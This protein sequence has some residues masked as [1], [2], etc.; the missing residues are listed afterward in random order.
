MRIS[1]RLEAIDYLHSLGVNAV[2]Y[3]PEPIDIRRDEPSRKRTDSSKCKVIR[4][5]GVSA[6]APAMLASG[7]FCHG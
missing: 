3:L 2:V 1:P 4:T 7:H 5:D 6:S